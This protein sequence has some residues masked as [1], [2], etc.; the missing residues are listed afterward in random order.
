[1]KVVDWS[2]GRRLPGISETGGER[3]SFLLCRDPAGAKRRSGSALARRKASAR[4]GN[5][6]SDYKQ[7]LE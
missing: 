6:Q 3:S 1:M 2:G 4:N 7:V 5:Q